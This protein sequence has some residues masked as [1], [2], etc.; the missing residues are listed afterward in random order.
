MRVNRAGGL[1]Q[2]EVHEKNAHE[3]PLFIRT[4]WVSFWLDAQRFLIRC[5]VCWLKQ[6]GKGQAQACLRSQRTR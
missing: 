3:C 1:H 6:T 2:D 4:E 5:Y